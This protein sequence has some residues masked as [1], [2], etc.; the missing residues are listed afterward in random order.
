MPDVATYD[1][2]LAREG[3]V[4]PLRYSEY[5]F[6]LSSVFARTIPCTYTLYKPFVLDLGPL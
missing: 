6:P 5:G 4:Y 2:R 3:S 1:R